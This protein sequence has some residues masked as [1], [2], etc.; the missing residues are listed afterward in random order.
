MRDLVFEERRADLR[1]PSIR[2]LAP[3]GK[4]KR[5][6]ATVK[7]RGQADRSRRAL[8]RRYHRSGLSRFL[9][10]TMSADPRE[11]RRDAAVKNKFDPQF[12]IADKDGK[13]TQCFATI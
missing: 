1:Q 13:P 7:N 10:A 4:V 8:A 12:A 3:Q 2:S 6:R 11:V 9:G 5:S